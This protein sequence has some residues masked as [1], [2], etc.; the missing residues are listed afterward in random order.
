MLQHL[1]QQN[2]QHQH[3]QQNKIE[4]HSASGADGKQ[5]AAMP[6]ESGSFQIK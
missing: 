4:R 6:A 1:Q 2:H 3:P 5:A